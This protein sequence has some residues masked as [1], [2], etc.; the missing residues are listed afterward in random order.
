MK[1]KI[2]LFIFLLFSN[3]FVFSNENKILFK[4]ENEIITSLDILNEIRYFD[5]IN[6]NFKDI[7][8]DKK[9]QIAKNSLI[10]DKIKKIALSSIVK[11]IELNNEDF[12]RIAISSYS[13][14]GIGNYEQLIDHL[15]QFN[16]DIDFFRKKISIS[17][18]W[19]QFIYDRYSQNI[20]IDVNQIKKNILSD[21]KQ[22]EYF[23]SEIVFDLEKNENLNEKFKLI[24][25][26]I[27]NDGFKN[28]AL[29]HSISETSTLGGELGW[30]KEKSINS[31]I[32]MEINNI[33]IN[34]FTN[35]ITIPGAF[36]ILKKND[37]R[38]TKREI[39]VEKELEQIIKIKTN[40]QLNQFSNLFLK[41]IKKDIVINEL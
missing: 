33:K 9:F 41:K 29:T 12:R 19:N 34:E 2:I 1:I 8:K 31:E 21:N 22:N 5:S 14:V 3:N 25:K 13:S 20:K 28:S 38:E 10:K 39:N 11:K 15:N 18:V 4:I 30:V 32:L 35:P 16:V 26:S 24:K 27:M 7:Q 17:S 40:E 36:L 23:L 37:I 6:N